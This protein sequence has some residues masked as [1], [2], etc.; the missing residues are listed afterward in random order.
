MR[1][2]E[3]EVVWFD[4]D[5]IECQVVC[6]NGS[7]TGTAKMYLGHDGL[8]NAAN[9]LSGFPSSATDL[10]Q[11]ELGSLESGTA[12]GGIQMSFY[13]VDSVGHAAVRVRLRA[14]DCKGFAEPQF[15]SLYVPVEA[16]AI[17]SFVK[18]AHSIGGTKG[19]KA[20]LHMA[21]HTLA[22]VRKA[23]A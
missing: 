5:A 6:S 1:G 4:H 14:D 16:G 18:Q 2:I 23:L 22:W 7:F 21:D 9:T 15:V 12:G 13:C 19:A 17:D 3:F 8:K 20:Y 10:R 11:V